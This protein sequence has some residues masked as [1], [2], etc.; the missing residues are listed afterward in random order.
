MREKRQFHLHGRRKEE[1][2]E[3]NRE[4]RDWMLPGI[5]PLVTE[6]K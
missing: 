1:E 6:A 3:K 4:W 2:E 5:V